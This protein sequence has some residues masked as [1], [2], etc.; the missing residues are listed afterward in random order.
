MRNRFARLAI[1]VVAAL[2]LSSPALATAKGKSTGNTRHK[3]AP[4]PAPPEAGRW[5]VNVVP[6]SETASKGEKE[7]DDTL[8]LNKGKFSSTA[9]IPYGFGTVPY[10]VEAGT[11]IANMESPKEGKA[12][13][14][15]EVT[16]DSIS[17]KMTWTKPDGTVLSYAF[18]GA[19]TGGSGAQT[20]KSH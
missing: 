17:G 11:W 20:Q 13:W 4:A 5:T 2:V 6:E 16:G 15:A 19:R 7:F 14:H 8:V 12:H 18:S 9:C 10:R 3:P 1:L